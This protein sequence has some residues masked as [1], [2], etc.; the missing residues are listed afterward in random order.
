MRKSKS[1]TMKFE[2]QVFV[3]FLL[4]LLFTGIDAQLD[5]C[6]KAPFNTKIVGG[7]DATL[8][9]WPWQ[10]VVRRQN[11]LCGGSL[12]SSL[13]V[14]T[15]AH[16]FESNSTSGVRV[17]FGTLTISGGNQNSVERT[18]SQ[19]IV[20]PDYNQR[21]N[22]ND[23]ALLKLASSVDFND[24][25]TPVCLAADGSII[26]NGI[27]TW[28]TGYGTTSSGG[29]IAQS[30]Q[31]VKVPVV[32]NSQCNQAYGGGITDNMLCAGQ[33]G[34][35]SCQ[36]DSGGPLVYKQDSQWTQAGVVS[37]GSGCGDANFPGVYARVSKYQSWINQQ[38]P[39]AEQP[40]YITLANISATA[41]PTTTNTTTTNT[42]NTT[43]TNAGSSPVIPVFL[44]LA[45]PL[46]ISILP[47][48]FSVFIFS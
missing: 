6:G 19:V 11:A 14:L 20:H 21:P 38:I 40:G 34:K 10:A 8:G 18:V 36:G 45:A 27:Q 37:F 7:Q 29:S 22:D 46:L 17:L 15:A 44:S 9:S 24:F 39:T 42:T 47:I 33:A 30:L 31:E 4:E 3:V 28:V 32:S 2:Q 13:W 12:I 25:V 26:N 41:P 16:C 43:T 23:V 48:I 1:H 35:D 5:V